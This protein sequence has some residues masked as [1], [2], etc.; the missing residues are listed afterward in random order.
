M[1]LIVFFLSFYMGTSAIADSSTFSDYN[2]ERVT[3]TLQNKSLKSIPLIIPGVMKPN[4]SPKSKSG[5]T[6]RI[7]QKILFKYKGKR[8][9]LLV[10]SKELAGKTLD[11]AELIKKAKNIIDGKISTNE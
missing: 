10:V 2:N 5:V 9:V 6:F 7:G 8:K 11:V 1:N 4:L 3:F